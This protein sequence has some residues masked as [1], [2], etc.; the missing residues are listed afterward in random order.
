VTEAHQ[1]PLL[2]YI[3]TGSAVV[4]ALCAVIGALVALRREQPTTSVVI[5]FATPRANPGCCRCSTRTR[6]R[7]VDDDD[8]GAVRSG[9]DQTSRRPCRLRGSKL[10]SE[11]RKTHATGPA[12]CCGV[13]NV[14]YAVIT[15]TAS[16][17]APLA[18]LDSAYEENQP[19]ERFAAYLALRCGKCAPYLHNPRASKI[20]RRPSATERRAAVCPS[21]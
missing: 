3:S 6:H 18:W 20:D 21:E 14:R 4:S 2:A 8:R 17:V 13:R 16:A 1:I 15:H 19:R 7:R 9:A 5:V 12:T 11:R 10:R